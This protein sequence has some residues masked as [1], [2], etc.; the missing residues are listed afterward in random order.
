[1]LGSAR[2]ARNPAVDSIDHEKHRITARESE[3]IG[4]NQ[5]LDSLACQAGRDMQERER[6]SMRHW[7]AVGSIADHPR[8]LTR[9][10]DSVTDDGD[11]KPH[12]AVSDRVLAVF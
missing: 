4:G 9:V 8:H 2:Q 7:P 12:A 11:R 3:A 5:L 10:I 6:Q 1:M